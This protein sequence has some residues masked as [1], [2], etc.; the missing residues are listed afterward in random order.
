MNALFNRLLAPWRRWQADAAA[1]A[2][3]ET[4]SDPRALENIDDHTNRLWTLLVASCVALFVWAAIFP[5]DVVSLSEGTVETSSGL[6][7][8]Q[9]L[10]GGIVRELLVKEGEHVAKGQVLIRMEQ[11]QSNS[12]F[13]E[14]DAR[15]TGLKA[16]RA[17]LEAEVAGAATPSFPPE[18]VAAH[19]EVV[20]RARDLFRARRETLRASLESQR[21]EI[22]Q[23][24]Q[25]IAEISARLGNTRSRHQL[26]VE[27]VTIGEKLIASELSNRY[28]QL[29]R[30][31]E[32]N[33]LKSRIEEDQQ[34]LIRARESV[35][36]ARATMAGIQ[37]KYDEDVRREL[38]DTRRQLSELANR[39]V[40]LKDTLSRTDLR[41]P[42]A[43]V[44][45]TRLVNS[46]GAVI[47]PGA[48]VIDIVPDDSHVV[49]E[50][51]LLPQDVGHVRVGQK[52][53]VQLA[54]SEATLFGQ[55]K[56]SV[57]HV[58]PDSVTDKDGRLSYYVVRVQTEKTYFQSGDVRY[59]LTSGVLVSV[60]IVTGSRTVLQYLLNPILRT[61]PFALTER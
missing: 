3:A 29:E 25:D 52:A 43:G 37:S 8:V 51:K 38:N 55:I 41:A 46:V 15:L 36:K 2:L 10:E 11:T 7:K 1:S 13:G 44:V 5:L 17:R 27:Q 28:E 21:R 19:P 20:S 16:D 26:A 35:D 18:L 22:S 54:S 57:S 60:G 6:Q 42:M 23:R 4:S 47:P 33:A 58:S 50:A 34:G 39:E 53:F 12:D 61:M 31:K 14:I 32:A 9:H 49:V 59:D 30:L 24:Q 40:K 45:K 56:G 48:I